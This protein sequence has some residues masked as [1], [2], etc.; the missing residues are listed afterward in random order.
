MAERVRAIPWVVMSALALTSACA[1]PPRA[2]DAAILVAPV[3]LEHWHAGVLRVHVLSVNGAHIPRGA[4]EGSLSTLRR[5]VGMPVDLFDH[6]DI[7]V[8]V[9][10][11]G[12]LPDPLPWPV[13][14]GER[15]CTLDDLSRT[16]ERTRL[17]I[18]ARGGIA[19]VVV[20]TNH[21][22]EPVLY[23]LIEPGVI[24]VAVVPG[25]PDGGGVTGYAAPVPS[26]PTAEMRTGL[27]VLRASAILRVSNWF[28]S[29]EKLWEWTLTHEAGHVLG[30]P[31]SNSHVWNVPGLG[32]HGTQPECVMYTG[33][34]WRVVVSGLLHGWPLDFCGCCAGELSTA[35]ASARD[36]AASKE[37]G[38][39]VVPVGPPGTPPRE[40]AS[41][42]P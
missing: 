23:P 30:V 15:E 16:P 13:R 17:L 37:P 27:V 1:V 19:G 22:A 5:H 38:G 12:R 41:S 11:N 42:P 31:A 18:E 32:A 3:R 14:V 35:R 21:A 9:D 29:A 40:V 36:G 4:L 24:L 6:G 2:G 26:T 25:S 8:A 7:S 20:K 10:A 34:D 33:L 28:V 39:P